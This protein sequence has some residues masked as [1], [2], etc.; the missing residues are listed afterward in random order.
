M[1]QLKDKISSLD[2]EQIKSDII[3]FIRPIEEPSIELW[4]SNFFI[5]S[6]ECYEKS[7]S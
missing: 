5:D 7:K 2:W 4:C 6:L 1:K 3:R